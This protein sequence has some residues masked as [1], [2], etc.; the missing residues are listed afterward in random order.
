[1][2]ELASILERLTFADLEQWAGRNAVERGRSYL[3]RVDG[4]RR[5]R[6]DD[7]VAW[8]SGNEDYA[9]LVRL[10]PQHQHSWYCTCP[11]EGG[12]CKHAVAV[13]LVAARQVKEAREIPQ[14]D[15][16]EDL[17]LMLFGDPEDELDWDEEREPDPVSAVMPE[18]S[19]K[20]GGAKIR[21]L[22]EGRSPEALVALLVD[23]A[24]IYPG[25]EQYL[26]ETEQL[27]TGQVDPLVRALRKEIIRL[28][29]EPAWRNHWSHEGSVPDYSHVQRQFQALLDSGH[30][31]SLLELGETLWREGTH[32]VEHSD[33]GGETAEALSECLEI[34]LKALPKTSLPPQQQLLWVIER[35]LDDEF[36][37]LVSGEDVL[38]APRYTAADWQALARLLEARLAIPGKAKSAQFYESFQRKA[39]VHRLLEAYRKSGEEEMIQPLLEREVEICHNYEELVDHFLESGQRQL[40]RE[41]CERGFQRSLQEAPGHAENLQKRLRLLAEQEKRYDL[42]TAYRA[43]DFFGSPTLNTYKELRK[44]AEKAKIWPRVRELILGYL[45]TG[46]RPDLPSKGA[47][48]GDWPL[49]APEVVFPVDR[50]RGENKRFP[51][52]DTLI[53]IAI[54]EKRMDDVVRLYEAA[55]KNKIEGWYLGERVAHAVAKTHPDVALAIWREAVDRLIAKV[56]PRA[57]TDAAGFL[58]QMGKVYEATGRQAEW[59]SLLSE[60]RQTHK[61]KRRLLEVLNSLGGG[62]RKI[63]R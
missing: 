56:K 18:K 53:D 29:E 49:P 25:I 52:Y 16:D 60:L 17:Y 28:T 32:Q 33:D 37:L 22:L 14:L 26:R 48:G 40:A 7:L 4:L 2:K 21:K 6:E 10:D 12:P 39:L 8:V 36:D 31:D 11:Y 63:T 9:T 62:G 59:R 23:L 45:E 61:A 55:K 38:R 15:Q 24:R 27:R 43:Q 51:F 35:R 44:A 54:V 20:T 3:K 58:R 5:T 34:A 19:V 13:I 30:F 50:D 47:E 41:W 57:Y 1:M 46:N 42:V